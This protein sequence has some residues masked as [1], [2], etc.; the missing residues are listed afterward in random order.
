M[1]NGSPLVA[2]K[3]HA[4]ISRCLKQF[5]YTIILFEGLRVEVSFS[6]NIIACFLSVILIAVHE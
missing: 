1:P 4:K 3:T 5:S 2:L 6:F